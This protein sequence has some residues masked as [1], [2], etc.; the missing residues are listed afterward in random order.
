MGSLLVPRRRA[1]VCI[2]AAVIILLIYFRSPVDVHR[3][4][5]LPSGSSGKSH[6][7][8]SKGKFQW[9]RV[10]VRYPVESITP[11]PAGAL[12]KLPK[13]Q[14]ELEEETAGEKQER[15][16]RL[17][18]IKKEFLHAWNGYKDHAWMSDEVMPV[19]GRTTNA[20]GGWAA[21]LV[22]TLGL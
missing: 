18:T 14:T 10:P 11:L 5:W 20:F 8:P 19:S 16:L 2:V 3:P 21:T 17:E 22:D 7:A 9:S 15:L 4:Q 6:V 12:T 13:I 1:T